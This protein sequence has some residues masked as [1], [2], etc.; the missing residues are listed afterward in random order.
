MQEQYTVLEWYMHHLKIILI[1]SHA[2]LLHIY[3]FKVNLSLPCRKL[4]RLIALILLWELK[5]NVLIEMKI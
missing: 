4:D 2:E 1:K 3:M 5:I